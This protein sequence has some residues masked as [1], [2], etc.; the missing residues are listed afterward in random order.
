MAF[1]LLL[2]FC[3]VVLVGAAWRIRGRSST[4]HDVAFAQQVHAAAEQHRDA[5]LGDAGSGGGWG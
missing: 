1:L 2:G 4:L 5:H 3:V